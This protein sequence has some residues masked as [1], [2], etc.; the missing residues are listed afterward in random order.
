MLKRFIEENY[1]PIETSIDK[2]DQL[3]KDHTPKIE[4]KS[5]KNNH[6]RL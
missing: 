4:F 2:G 5:M 6:M 1:S 3:N